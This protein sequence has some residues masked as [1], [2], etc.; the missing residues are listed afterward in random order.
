MLFTDNQEKIAKRAL[1]GSVFLTGFAGSGKTTIGKIFLK[2]LLEQDTPGNKILVLVPQKSLGLTYSDFLESVEIY[3]GNLPVIQTISGISQ[4]I[5]RLFWPIIAPQFKFNHPK[6]Y[7]TFL[8]IESAQYFMAKV[9]DPFFEKNYFSSIKSEKP[10]ILSQIL[11]NLNKSALVGFPHEEIDLRLK[12]AWSK[13]S[14]H[15]IAYDEAQ[16][17]AN[18]FRNYCLEFNLID[19]SL[20]YEIFNKIIHE[21]FLIQQYLF[22]SYEYLIYDNCEEDTPVAH[23]LILKWLSG[24]KSALVIQDENAGFRSFLGADST[25]AIRLAKNCQEIIEVRDSFIS[26]PPIHE[27]ISI[28]RNALSHQPIG[29]ISEPG[30]R[31]LSFHH[32]KFYPD[33]INQ[34]VQQIDDFIKQGINPGK[35]AILAPFVSN[36]LRFQIQQRMIEK[37]IKLV[38]HRPSRSLREESITHGLISWT[39]LAYPEWGLLPSVYQFRT[40]ITHAI[41]DMD[42]I[43]ADLLSRIVLTKNNA[44]ALRPI[45]VVRPEM[46]ERITI[47]AVF[48][49]QKIFSWLVNYQENKSEVDVFL[50]SFFGEILSQPGFGFHENYEG[51]E[52]TGRLIE[53]MQNFRKNTLSHFQK[54]GENWALD[55][56]T[57]LENG[58]I[59]AL[60]LQT[61]DLPPQ[62]AVYLAPAHTFL[63]QNRPVEIQIWLDIGNMGWWQRLM[64]PL[65]Q[66]YVLSRNWKDGMKWTDIHEYENNQKNL[67]KLISGLLRR[68]SGNLILHT[69]GYNENG[70]EQTGP[71]LKATQRI[72]RTYHR[73]IGNKNV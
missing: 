63:M 21:S 39:K 38:T 35:I 59:S 14:N 4:K 30:F 49:Y 44:F 64:Q 37:N 7:P 41:G 54:T 5:I 23:D 26:G 72:L 65:T 20:Q 51:A 69:T 13:E 66:P 70:D 11:D 10:R 50:A 28:Y 22:N 17:C 60:Y 15:I 9:C 25:S 53:S 19:F 40:A 3:N 56:I 62:D 32:H 34:V 24:L 52:I 57:M 55:Y 27:I 73:Q 61:W 58:L 36:A 8:N 43:R 46:L 33:M 2:L 29:G 67:E 71:L 6:Q 48:Q 16:E 47:Q 45:D 68:C 18:A 31:R 12:S 1:E 42:P